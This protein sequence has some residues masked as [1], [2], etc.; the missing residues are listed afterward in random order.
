M[1]EILL[2]IKVSC[3]SKMQTVNSAQSV[4]KPEITDEEIKEKEKNFFVDMCKNET[5]NLN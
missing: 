3:D 1:A 2:S 4:L 5:E